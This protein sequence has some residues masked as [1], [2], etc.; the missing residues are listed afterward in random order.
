[1]SQSFG[2]LLDRGERREQDQQ[3]SSTLLWSN[4]TRLNGRVTKGCKGNTTER[5]RERERKELAPKLL[6]G[7]T[8]IRGSSGPSDTDRARASTAQYHSSV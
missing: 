3:V 7:T 5:E 1:M 8:T 4:T 6:P 2:L